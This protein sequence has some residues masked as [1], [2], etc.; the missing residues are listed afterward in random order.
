MT[1]EEP[2][3]PETPLTPT[4]LDSVTPVNPVDFEATKRPATPEPS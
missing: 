1:L 4:A 2:A 3:V